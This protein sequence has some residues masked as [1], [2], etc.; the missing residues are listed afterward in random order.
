[1]LQEVLKTDLNFGLGLLKQWQNNGE[2][3]KLTK[4]E[5]HFLIYWLE[6]DIEL[7]LE[8]ESI[9]KWGINK[10]KSIVRKLKEEK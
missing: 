8:L 5:K 6:E 9:N 10:L 3:M 4:K 7:G 1:M 2:I